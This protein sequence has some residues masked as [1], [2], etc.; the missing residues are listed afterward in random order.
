VAE[1]LRTLRGDCREVLATIDERFDIIIS[2]PPTAA[3]GAGGWVL[4]RDYGAVLR[5]ALNRLAPGGLLVACCNTIGGKP[6]DLV[7]AIQEQAAQERLVL[8][9]IDGPPL[10]D[11][12]PQLDG[13]PEGRPFRLVAMRS[14]AT[15]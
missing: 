2:D 14:A 5:L 7:G 13:F 3:Q 1:R 15:G 12:Q 4:R 9:R 8:S 11:D 6:F 10:G